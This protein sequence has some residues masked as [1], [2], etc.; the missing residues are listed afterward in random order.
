MKFFSPIDYITSIYDVEYVTQTMLSLAKRGS[1][2]HVGSKCQSDDVYD[3]DTYDV[4]PQ[5]SIWHISILSCTHWWQ[6]NAKIPQNGH[7][8]IE[9]FPIYSCPEYWHY[10]GHNR[11]NPPALFIV[12]FFIYFIVHFFIYFIVHFFIYKLDR[13]RDILYL[14]SCPNYKERNAHLFSGT[15]KMGSSV[16]EGPI[17]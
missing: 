17:Q 16:R 6:Y 7:L 3:V 12:H 5:C 2:F 11:P 1:I 9:I 10:N 8:A 13:M 15:W 4:P 14:T